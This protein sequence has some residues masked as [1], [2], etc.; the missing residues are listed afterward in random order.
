MGCCARMDGRPAPGFTHWLLASVT[1]QTAAPKCRVQ[2]ATELA[3]A[4]GQLRLWPGA[5][6]VAALVRLLVWRA[7]CG[8]RRVA[9]VSP[10][11][12][13]RLLGGLAR[14]PPGASG[15]GTAEDDLQR[16]APG[17]DANLGLTWR[18][19]GLGVGQQAQQQAVAA[20]AGAQ[21]AAGRVAGAAGGVQQA[22]DAPPPTSADQEVA[23]PAAER[24]VRRVHA[25]F[26]P[27]R[28][29][30]A[31]LARAASTAGTSDTGH[32]AEAVWA[33]TK[34]GHPPPSKWLGELVAYA[35]GP[36][37]HLLGARPAL[38]LLAALAAAPQPVAVPA[39]PC[40][41]STPAPSPPLAVPH[42]KVSAAESASA[43]A[44][45]WATALLSRLAERVAV[46]AGSLDVCKDIPLLAALMSDQLQPPPTPGASCPAHG[47]QM[48][49]GQRATP[50]QG[51]GFRA[52]AASGSGGTS[53]AQVDIS[54]SAAVAALRQ[55]V[56]V[57]LPRIPSL[58]MAAL[59]AATTDAGYAPSPEWGAA[60]ESASLAPL[61]NAPSFDG[62]PSPLRVCLLGAMLFSRHRPSQGWLE[63]WCSAVALGAR[64]LAP[65]QLL[66]ALRLVSVLGAAA[67][68]GSASA[69][70]T[71]SMSGGS[72]ASGGSQSAAGARSAGATAG[73]GVAQSAVPWVPAS[74]LQVVEAAALASCSPALDAI[75]TAYAM[76][77]L[78]DG[79]LPTAVAT[80]RA[81]ARAAAA[82]VLEPWG[83]GKLAVLAAHLHMLGHDV[84]TQLEAAAQLAVTVHIYGADLVAP[85]A[86]GANGRASIQAVEQ[87]EQ[88][89]SAELVA[90]LMEVAHLQPRRC[91]PAA[92]HAVALLLQ[93]V[94]QGCSSTS[95][96]AGIAAATAAP[97][98]ALPQR[99]ASPAHSGRSLASGVSRLPHRSRR[100]TRD[101]VAALY[102]ALS[103][104]APGGL[105]ARPLPALSSPG[106]A[107]CA[108]MDLMATWG[109]TPPER[110]VSGLVSEAC[111]PGA[112]PGATPTPSATPSTT[113][114]AAG[115]DVA[116]LGVPTPL[117][118]SH[119]C[120]MLRSLA[121]MQAAVSQES[122]ERLLALLTPAALRKCSVKQ[123][124]WNDDICRMT[125]SHTAC[126]V[127]LAA[128][129]AGTG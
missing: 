17:F 5:R 124:N 82:Q 68:A 18:R 84:S 114:A 58:H 9:D 77:A 120:A 94:V 42:A 23:V 128:C 104:G 38:C 33:A 113:A 116:L 107:L 105:S 126:P 16:A 73:A 61:S 80:A 122:M 83:A 70:A 22:P 102:P 6:W 64:H 28:L 86:G 110:W 15:N 92:S 56:Q 89:L 91:G 63:A 29:V 44:S 109:A 106:R 79:S 87:R 67:P 31:L 99:A 52:T 40:S 20:A 54:G 88:H 45:A 121:L 35:A 25:S 123:V 78:P 65:A 115:A 85:A 8:S 74:F 71:R 1:R 13:A 66:A 21:V 60:V 53:A 69:A 108:V 81:E 51:S 3:W 98:A 47:D 46:G 125:V 90:A 11:Q 14:L 72:T 19:D 7:P 62:V 118:P 55:A 24:R 12:V 48:H 127:T 75:Q 119:A 100:P 34:L 93:H 10:L 43:A 4:F 103:I 32:L 26:V 2:C 27:P 111:R 36:K 97:A 41:S 57:G 95:V 59:V 37:V 129:I 96:L 39:P 76:P 49:H 101:L 30:H 50:A 112:T 117:L